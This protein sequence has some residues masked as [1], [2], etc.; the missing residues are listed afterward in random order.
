L[1]PKHGCK[2][3]LV[4]QK[5]SQIASYTVYRMDGYGRVLMALKSEYN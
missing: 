4:A 3:T 5:Y 2:K 1:T